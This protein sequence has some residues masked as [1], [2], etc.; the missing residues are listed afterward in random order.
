MVW[1]PPPSS[2]AVLTVNAAGDTSARHCL[3]QPSIWKYRRGGEHHRHE[4]QFPCG[5]NN[6]YFCPGE[7]ECDRREF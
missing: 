6:V 5:S 7:G 1:V 2:N 3:F 4:F